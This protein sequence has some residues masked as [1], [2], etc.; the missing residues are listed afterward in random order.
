MN[1]GVIASIVCLRIAD[2]CSHGKAMAIQA[3]LDVDI[4]EEFLKTKITVGPNWAE[5]F[6]LLN[7]ID[8]RWNLSRLP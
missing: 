3:L 6:T 2:V 8:R 5:L 4:L 7:S 1:V